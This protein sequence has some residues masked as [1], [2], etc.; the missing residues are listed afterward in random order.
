MKIKIYI[1]AFFIIIFIGKLITI[2]SNIFGLIFKGNEITFADP[3]CPNHKLKPAKEINSFHKYSTLNKIKI[4]IFC[5]VIYPV[6]FF[7]ISTI[8]KKYNY[9]KVNYFSFLV[10]SLY[11]FKFYPPPK[12]NF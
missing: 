10:N 8:L 4:D 5:N 7:Q 2:D 9:K 12:F 1:A 6:N 11:S 3:F